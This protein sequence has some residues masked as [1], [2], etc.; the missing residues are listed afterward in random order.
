VEQG[1]YIVVGWG[2]KDQVS[3]RRKTTAYR[4]NIIVKI[5]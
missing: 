4:I 3:R 2:Q 5:T 1:K